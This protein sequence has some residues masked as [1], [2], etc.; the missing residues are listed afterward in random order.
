MKCIKMKFSLKRLS[1][2]LLGLASLAILA[3][4][5]ASAVLISTVE[6]HVSINATKSVSL[7]ASSTFYMF[8]AMPLSSATVAS[9]SITVTND[10]GAYVETYLLAGADAISDTGGQN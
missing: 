6:I 3:P 4:T 2:W 5:K 9:S 7:Q 8:G 1:L 10:S